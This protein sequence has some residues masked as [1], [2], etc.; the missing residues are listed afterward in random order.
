MKKDHG[1]VVICCVCRMIYRLGYL[2]MSHGYCRECADK[3]MQEMK[4][5]KG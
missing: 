1:L 3:L 2:P 5:A 4:E